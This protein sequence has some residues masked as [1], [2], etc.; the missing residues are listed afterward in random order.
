MKFM[1][2]GSAAAEACPSLWCNCEN[3]RKAWKNG[4]KDIRRRTSYLIDDD[5]WIDFGPDSF[6]QITTFLKG[7]P[8]L[9]QIFFTHC[10]TDHVAPMELYWRHRGFSA[11]ADPLAV[12]GVPELY[13]FIRRVITAHANASGY[14]E[15][16]LQCNV[17]QPGKKAKAE[18]LEY[19]A[20]PANHGAPNSVNYFFKRAGKTI[21][22]ANDT[23]FWTPESWEMAEGQKADLAILDGTSS[24]RY[25]DQLNGHMGA[26]TVIKFRDE[27]LKR[28]IITKKTTVIVNHFSHNGN[29]LQ[30][31]LEKFYDPKGI[32]VGYDGLTIE[33]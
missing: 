14:T 23:G 4:G 25:P 19:L 31:D 3:C 7:W 12:Y 28:H 20:I 6:S 15:L 21:L 29:S 33:L 13:E 16:N 1:I 5:T 11:N 18:N 2:L 9:K 17:V 26:N 10:H 24:L 30:R 32:L 8:A 22:I 27:L